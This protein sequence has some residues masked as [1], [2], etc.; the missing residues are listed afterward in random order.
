MLSH[1]SLAS[2]FLTALALAGCSDGAVSPVT[3][4]SQQLLALASHA[5]LSVTGH[6]EFTN[7]ATGTFARYSFTAVRYTDGT[8]TGEA[9]YFQETLAGVQTKAHSTITCFT[10]VGNAVR[11]GAT[12]DRVDPL[13]PLGIADAFASVEDNGEGAGEPADRASFASL[14]PPGTAQ[15]HCTSGLPRTLFPIE[16]GNI[17]VR[18]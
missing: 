7:P 15:T 10:I 17:Q 8:V 13:V 16:R 18:P 11:V 14:G 2:L 1:T 12:I 9:Q 5:Q 4:P 6:A 3:D